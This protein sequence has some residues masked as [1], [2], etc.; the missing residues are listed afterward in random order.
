MF[1][2]NV[3]IMTPAAGY[4][5]TPHKERETSKDVKKKTCIEI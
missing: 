1:L 5:F 4:H 3:E 2:G